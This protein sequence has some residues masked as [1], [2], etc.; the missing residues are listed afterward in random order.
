MFKIFYCQHIYKTP[1]LLNYFLLLLINQPFIFKAFYKSTQILIDW[2]KIDW[3][4]HS[5]SLFK[6]KGENN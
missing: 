1:K 4:I 5:F 2:L 3:L 6:I